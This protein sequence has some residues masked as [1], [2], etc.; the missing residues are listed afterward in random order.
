MNLLLMNIFLRCLGWLCLSLIEQEKRNYPPNLKVSGIP[1][2]MLIGP[3]GK[4]ITTEGRSEVVQDPKGEKFPW[5]PKSF[6]ELIEGKIV[7]KDGKETSANSLKEND[8]IGIYFSAHWCGPCR[9]FTPKL[10][11]AYQK[12]KKDGKSIEI[13]FASADKDEEQYKG[14]YATMPWKTLPFGD[15][16]ERALSTTFHVRGIPTLVFLDKKGDTISVNGRSLIED[17]LNNY[18]W[19]QTPFQPLNSSAVGPLNEQPCLI[20]FPEQSKTE[21]QKKVVATVAEEFS[22]KEKKDDDDSV[23]NFYYEVDN[24]ILQQIASA[25]SLNLF[26]RP[27]VLI[28]DVPKYSKYYFK[29]E[30]TEENVRKFVNEFLGGKAKAVPLS[31]KPQ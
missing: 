4:V 31:D 30:I 21:E 12:L 8:V 16:R 13:V 5:L 11:E 9:A 27:V 29:G 2:F 23:L 15:K 6:W 22:K 24:P 7:G 19:P 17:E 18:P 10:I 28:V 25:L 1:Y 3:D 26:D 20:V 14:Y